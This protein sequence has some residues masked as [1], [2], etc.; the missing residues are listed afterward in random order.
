MKKRI[1]VHALLVVVALALT[2]TIVFAALEPVGTDTRTNG[3]TTVTWDSRFADLDY[4]L[5]D[6]ITMTVTWT[7]DVGDAEYDS[8]GLGSGSF[9]PRSR[10]DPAKGEIVTEAVQTGDNSVTIEFKF[11][12]LHTCP[13]RDVEMGNAHFN[14]YLNVDMDGDKEPDKVVSY[15]VNVLVE[16]PH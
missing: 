12:G 8:F 1:L 15:G 6:T 9:T 10:Q 7:V 11:T 13:I 16:E 3:E 5:G 4:T 14:L 2:A